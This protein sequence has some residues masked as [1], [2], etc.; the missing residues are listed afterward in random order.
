MFGVK[1]FVRIRRFIGAL[2]DVLDDFVALDSR[3]SCR[4]GYAVSY[5]LKVRDLSPVLLEP[6]FV[7]SR[8]FLRIIIFRSYCRYGRVSLACTAGRQSGCSNETEIAGI[9][10]PRY[11]FAGSDHFLPMF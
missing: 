4:L 1:S 7:I 5:L 11:V 8:C 6:A 10:C 3:K 9:Y 2:T